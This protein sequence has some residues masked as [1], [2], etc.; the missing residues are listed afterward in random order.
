MPLKDPS[1]NRKRAINVYSNLIEKT[2]LDD[3]SIE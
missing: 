1:N 2:F 3:M